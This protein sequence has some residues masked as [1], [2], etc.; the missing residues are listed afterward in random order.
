MLRIMR[1]V[2]AFVVVL[3][4]GAASLARA[5]EQP[6]F[7]VSYVMDQLSH[8][9]E[10]IHALV[11]RIGR[12]PRA[13]GILGPEHIKRF[14][15]IVLG[16]QFEALDTFPTMTVREMGQAVDLAARAMGPAEQAGA[17][18]AVPAAPAA[19][20]EALGIPSPEAPPTGDLYLRHVGFE[21]DI[22]DRIDETLAP[23]FGD[24][25]RLAAVL[26]RL[27]RNV[28]GEP[29]TYRVRL[30]ETVASS[31]EQLLT[32]LVSQ[33]HTVE[34]RDARY[35]AN[36][37][38]LIYQGRDVLTP[39]WLD[40]EILIPGQERTLR[41]PAS[42]SQHELR[43]HGPLV[44]ADLAFFFGIDG[45]A[46]LRP[47]VTRD[48]AW[49]YGRVARSYR[50]PDAG[51]VMRFIA[52]IIRTYDRVK[53][54]HPTLPFGGYYALGVCNDVNAMIEMH[55]QGETTLF[56]LTHDPALFTGH[57]EVDNVVHRLPVDGRDDSTPDARRILGSLPVDDLESLALPGLRSDLA[58]V[59]TA[60]DQGAVAYAQ[61]SRLRFWAR[62]A[63]FGAIGVLWMKPLLAAG[64]VLLALLL[65]WL[66]WRL[67]RR[68]T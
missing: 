18:A 57:G 36:F 52:A 30:G 54:E 37:G 31:C 9:E 27:A 65:L 62:L 14:R 6:W 2:R 1:I 20:E 28:P 25:S 13:G 64:G 29:P 67:T 10:F 38:D 43:V 53:G 59:R 45:L 26:N 42:H 44:N 56:P 60:F 55:M 58:A 50:G 51:E 33:G 23:R 47:I 46:E 24:A 40:T 35:F 15:E 11:D 61:S 68:R 41:V 5:E 4:L 21:L 19:A 16:K 63:T 48:Q 12:D 49:T 17:A 3:V 22:G 39:F 8:N 32:A 7:S 34:I 66:G